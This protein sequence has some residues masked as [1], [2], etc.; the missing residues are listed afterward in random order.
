MKKIFLVPLLLLSILMITC[1]PEPM[2]GENDDNSSNDTLPETPLVRKYLV[3]EYM[4]DRN[5]PSL[6]IKWNDDFTRIEYITT[7]SGSMYQVNYHFQYYEED[8]INVYTTVPEVNQGTYFFTRYT[9]HLNNGR[10]SSLDTYF[11]DNFKYTLHYEYDDKNKLVE[12]G[13][14]CF[15]WE[16]DNVKKMYYSNGNYTIVYD[17][18]IAETVDP[19][20]TLPYLLPSSTQFTSCGSYITKPLWK[21]Y[22]KWPGDYC[23]DYECD[24]DGYVTNVYII[25]E[26]G[27]RKLIYCYE[28]DY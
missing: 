5:K 15:V 6:I 27:C 7:D 22:R 4:T 14:A 18:V 21:N 26:E 20:Y 8:S 11:N 16:G 9:C 3:R 12:A 28:Y 2:P 19:Y 24:S 1:R 25:T 17:N 13:G 10:I 23:Y